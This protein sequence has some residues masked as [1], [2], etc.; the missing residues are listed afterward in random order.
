MLA[1]LC[2]DASFCFTCCLPV[3]VVVEV[4]LAVVVVLVGC[5]EGCMYC[6]YCPK[7]RMIFVVAF[8]LSMYSTYRIVYSSGERSST[9]C[10]G[11]RALEVEYFFRIRNLEVLV[12]L[13]LYRSQLSRWC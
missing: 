7:R 8:H 3:A 1:L 10:A 6:M 13:A 11:S 2:L 12:K 4:W 9:T 5:D